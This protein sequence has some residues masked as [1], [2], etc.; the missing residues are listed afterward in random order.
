MSVPRILVVGCGG[1]SRAWLS[2]VAGFNDVRI[3]GLVDIDTVRAAKGMQE[4]AIDGAQVFADP[5]EAL[6]TLS[7]DIVFDLTPPPVHHDV[8]TASIR[9]GCHV[10]GEKPMAASMDEARRMAELAAQAGVT[11]AVMQNRRYTPMMK[12]FRELLSGGAVGRCTAINADF[13][14]G[15]HFGG[16]RDEMDHVL[17]LDMAI[18]TFDQARYLCGCDPVAVYCHEWNPHGSWYRHGAAA[19]A[20]F[21]MTGGVVFTY[22]G[23]WCA[24]GHNTPWT[25]S[26]RVCGS[27]GAVLWDGASSLTAQRPSS[28]SGF[29][30]PVN[31]IDIPTAPELVHQGHAGCIREYLDCVRD[32]RKPQTSYDDN[33]RSL[34]MVHGA[35]KS[36]TTGKRVPIT[37]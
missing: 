2:A 22:C 3:A 9:H 18:H 17:L 26:W 27:K 21:E 25:A 35:I 33:I 8:V 12:Q 23:S 29:I 24:E 32:G 13:Y 1:I 11:Y 31:D 5:H 36:A 34:A 19:A 7:P 20:I 16:F 28:E 10:L 14:I 15:A 30:R 6:R 37:V 4:H